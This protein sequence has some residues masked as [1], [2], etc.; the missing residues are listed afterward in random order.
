[1]ILSVVGEDHSQSQLFSYCDQGN[2]S[3]IKYIYAPFMYEYFGLFF[4][5]KWIQFVFF[6]P[7]V[8]DELEILRQ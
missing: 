4:L 2:A 6:F 7:C 5:I 3:Q 8:S 1:M